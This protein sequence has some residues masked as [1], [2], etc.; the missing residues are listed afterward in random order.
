MRR[1]VLQ[2]ELDHGAGIGRF[3]GAPWLH[4]GRSISSVCSQLLVNMLN[5]LGTCTGRSV[6]REPIQAYR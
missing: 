1:G 2:R 5:M 6:L 3:A 4:D